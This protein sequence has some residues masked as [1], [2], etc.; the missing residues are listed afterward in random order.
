MPIKFLV[1]GEGGFGERG[2]V[3]GSANF[4]NGCG[5]FSDIRIIHFRP[6]GSRT[7]SKHPWAKTAFSQPG[8]IKHPG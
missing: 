1:L 4:L 6:L 5:D 8:Y 7:C 2:E 3:G